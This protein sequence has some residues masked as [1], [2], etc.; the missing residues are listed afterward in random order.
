MAVLVLLLLIWSARYFLLGSEAYFERQ[1]EVYQDHTAGLLLHIGGMMVAAAMGPFQFLRGLRNRHP[2]LHRVMGRVYLSGIAVGGLGGL[3][4]STIS[5]SGIV[6]DLGFGL[7]ALAVLFASAMAFLAI[8]GR[9]LQEHREW[10]TRSFAL[11]L[12]AVTLRIYLPFLEAT[13]GEQDGYALVAWL[14]WLPNLVV[15]EWL[16]RS[17][18]RRTPERGLAPA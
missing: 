11:V 4:L 2:K 7:L 12:A 16:I 10:M 14:C 1:L 6:S 18:L 5:A 9:R 3:Y 15:A 13:L 8:K 17:R